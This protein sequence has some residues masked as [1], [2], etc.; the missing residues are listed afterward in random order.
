VSIRDSIVTVSLLGLA[1]IIGT[2][3]HWIGM[4][5]LL[6]LFASR[7]IEILVQRRFAARRARAVE[8]AGGRT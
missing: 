6:L 2:T 3:L 4:W 1:L 5:A 7:P 8:Q